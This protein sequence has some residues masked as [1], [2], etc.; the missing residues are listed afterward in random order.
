MVHVP[1]ANKPGLN[2]L[3]TGGTSA[4]ETG[5]FTV[6]AVQPIEYTVRE[7]PDLLDPA[8]KVRVLGELA[9]CS[10]TGCNR[11]SLLCAATSCRAASKVPAVDISSLQCVSNW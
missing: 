3:T 11:A 1:Q 10:I 5:T 6:S 8:N 2:G 7:V 9:L 4:L